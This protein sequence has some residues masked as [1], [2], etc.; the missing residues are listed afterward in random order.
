MSEKIILPSNKK[1][2]YFFAFIFFI[3]SLYSFYEELNLYFFTLPSIIFSL[4]ILLISFFK[5]E[6]LY[7]Y[8]LI[9]FKIGLFLGK[10]VNPIILGFI[11]FI[12]ISPIAIIMR[13]FNRDELNL[14]LHKKNTYF[15]K[16]TSQIKP[17]SFKNQY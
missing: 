17:E 4:V 14:R 3:F 9:W 15:H 8:N 6:K 13:L 10:I 12:V 5:D 1:F 16:R 11:F 2:G 7:L